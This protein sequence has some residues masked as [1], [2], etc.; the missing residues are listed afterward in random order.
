MVNINGKE[1][2]LFYSIEAHIEI[3]NF[4]IANPAASMTEGVIVRAIAMNE[5]YN[6]VHKGGNV[7]K[8]E[9]LLALPNSI[10]TLLATAVEE[11]EK[12]DSV[13]SVE[14]EKPKGKNAKSAGQ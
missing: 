6:K 1:Y 7:L 3:D 11:Q 10:F 14:T 2:G 13:I 5:A 8:K 9:D 4:I 12:A